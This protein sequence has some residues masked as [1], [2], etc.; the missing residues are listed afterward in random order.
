MATN[1]IVIASRTGASLYEN[2]GPGSGMKFIKEVQH[3][4][5]RL[6]EGDI[7]SDRPGRK[8]NPT[9]SANHHGNSCSNEVSAT[10]KLSGEFARQL[11]DELESG[12]YAKNYDSLVLAAEPKFMGIIK[13]LLGP[14]TKSKLK[15]LVQ[16]ELVNVSHQELPSFFEGVLRL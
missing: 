10:E 9:V 11:A 5:G 6:K 15:E 7:N 2:T 4:R 16:K 14:H 1:L 8:G 12:A 3:P 13:P